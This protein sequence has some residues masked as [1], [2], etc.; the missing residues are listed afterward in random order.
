[1][2]QRDTSLKSSIRGKYLQAG[3]NS[4]VLAGILS[5]FHGK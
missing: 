3:W 5:G 2:L 4:D 1:V